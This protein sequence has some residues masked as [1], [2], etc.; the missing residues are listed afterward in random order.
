MHELTIIVVETTNKNAICKGCIFN[1]RITKRP[2]HIIADTLTQLG[3]DF[4]SESRN[5]HYELRTK[6]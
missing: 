1:P 2:C 3:L 5:L 6:K 4:C